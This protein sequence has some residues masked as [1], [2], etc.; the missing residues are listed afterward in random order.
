VRD[1]VALRLRADGAADARARADELLDRVGLAERGLAYPRQ[2]SGGEQQRVAVCAAVAHQPRL[3]LA[4]EPTGELD[5]AAADATFELI[6]ELAGDTGATAIVVTHDPAASAYADR[7]VRIRDGRVSEER[8]GG[9]EQIIVARG[10]WIRLPEEL[11]QA[12]GV[13][14]RVG[15]RLR[16]GEIVVAAP[17][18]APPVP[19]PAAPP[20]VEPTSPASESV[21]AELRAVSKRYGTRRVLEEI[22][23]QAWRGVLTAITGP[24]GSG[25]TTLVDVLLGLEQP[26]SG[27]VAILGR[28][29]TRADRDGRAAIRRAHVGYVAQQPA[30]AGFLTARE[31]IEL[32]LRLRGREGNA[33]RA[34]VD[35]G[36]AD[37]VEQRVERLSSGERLRVAIARAL[38]ARPDLLVADEPTA[39]LDEPNARRIASLLARLAREWGAAV[40]VA[41]HDATVAEQADERIELA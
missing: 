10:G 39:R 5:R 4:D 30:L 26:D 37:R 8:H 6:R 16:D 40:V 23:A 12:A 17:G 13:R 22:D 19:S 34:L 28:S 2:L 31:N 15:A 25:K 36:L 41:T 20:A 7:T 29:V 33:V 27:D 3:L 32:G 38:A 21:V 35:V 9:A 18:D 1:S 24:S 11:L 14:D